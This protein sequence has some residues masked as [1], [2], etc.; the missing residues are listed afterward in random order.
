MNYKKH[1]DNLILSR[2]NRILDES[3]HYEQH[4]ILPVCLG[5]SNDKSNLVKLTYKEH[6]I[7]HKLLFLFSEGKAKMKMGYALHRMCTINNNNQ[8]YRIKSAS[9]FEK[10]KEEVYN[11]IKGENHPS[12]GR[13]WSEE[14]KK[15]I[16]KR[17]KGNGNS[18]NGKTPWNKGLSKNTNDKVRMS[19]NK[20]LEKYK[21]NEI[22]TSNFGKK[23]EQGR[24]NISLA[25]KG[26]PKTNE[27]KLKLSKAL[28]GR[29]LSK[30]TKQKMSESRKGIPQKKIQCPYC[31]KIGGT[32]M[33]R[34]HFENCKLKN[35]GG[36][37]NK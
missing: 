16:S 26:K 32:T 30:E 35:N 23:T 33:H 8:T 5:G 13:K 20:L 6:F 18:M 14:E 29:K 37:L 19:T 15:A 7:A 21:N 22:D 1:Y 34:W 2:K 10:I 3:L 25:Q 17:Q 4:H 31:D 9:E 28:K 24:K 11:F 12:Y 27:C 36:K